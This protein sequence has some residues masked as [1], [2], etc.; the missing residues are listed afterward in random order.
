[1]ADPKLTPSPAKPFLIAT[2]YDGKARGFAIYYLPPTG[3]P[4]TLQEEE[5]VADGS[6]EASALE[7]T[8]SDADHG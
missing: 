8:V 3:Q 2:F 5:H 4:V 1:M 6:I 7:Q